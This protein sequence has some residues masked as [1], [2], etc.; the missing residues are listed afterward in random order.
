MQRPGFDPWVGKIPWRREGYPLQYSGLENSMNY[1]PWGHK[2][3]DTTEWLSLHSLKWRT[4]SL[5]KTLM[6]RNWRQKEKGL[7]EEMFRKHHCLSGHEFEQILENS[8]GQKSL[9]G[10]CP[11]IHTKQHQ[12]Y[13]TLCDPM[14]CSLPCSS[15]HGILQARILEWVTMPSSKGSSWPSDWIQC[16]VS[17]IG[18]W[19]L[20]HQHH[21]GGLGYSPW[22]CKELDSLG[23]EQQLQL[24]YTDVK[25]CFNTTHWSSAFLSLDH[26][27]NLR[28][29]CSSNFWSWYFL[30]WQTTLQ[31]LWN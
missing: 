28:P 7:A 5:E 1:S 18:R 10:Y 11:C 23:T 14:D 21:L 19:V 29:C 27:N 9:S 4:D 20:Y 31:P 2:K 12:S 15:V 8:G 24:F 16:H 17:C 22:G 6:L 3:S 13:L 25:V 26:F 30:F